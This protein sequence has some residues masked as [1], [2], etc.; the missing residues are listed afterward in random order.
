M[1]PLT[2]FFV[3]LTALFWTDAFVLAQTIP[4]GVALDLNII[5]DFARNVG[6]YLFTFAGVLAGITL[7]WA[8][9]TYLT[10]GGDSTK[11]KK[12]KDILKAGII[13][14]FII[15]GTGVILSTVNKLANDPAGFFGGGGGGGNNSLPNGSVCGSGNDCQSYYCNL[16]R[17]PPVCE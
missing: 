1:N 10:A 14:A 16:N 8:G 6:N 12:A 11:T 4:T 7:V 13:G 3:L 17:N 2:V 5:L 15:F 9:V